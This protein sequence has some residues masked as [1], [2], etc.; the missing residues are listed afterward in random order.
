MTQEMYQDA[1][2][3]KQVYFSDGG[4]LAVQLKDLLGFDHEQPVS[5]NIFASR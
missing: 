5:Y 2:Y 3:L 1:R 4:P